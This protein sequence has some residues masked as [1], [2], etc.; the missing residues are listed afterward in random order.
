MSNSVVFP[1]HFMIL[2]RSACLRASHYYESYEY[3]SYLVS[4]KSI[5]TRRRG[6]V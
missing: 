4:G 5:N 1:K 3:S 6:L 2:A